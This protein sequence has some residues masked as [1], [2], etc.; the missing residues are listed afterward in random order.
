MVGV[1]IKDNHHPSAFWVKSTPAGGTSQLSSSWGRC[2][3]KH[4]DDW[5]PSRWLG[6][7][8]A[9]TQFNCQT[10]PDW[11]QTNKH[12]SWNIKKVFNAKL[13]HIYCAKKT[14]KNT[15]KKKNVHILIVVKISQVKHNTIKSG[16]TS[17]LINPELGRRPLPQQRPPV[18]KRQSGSPGE[19]PVEGNHTLPSSGGRCWCDCAA[20]PPPGC[21]AWGWAP[22]PSAVHSSWSPPGSSPSPEH[23]SQRRSPEGPVEEAAMGHV[24]LQAAVVN[25][26][27]PLS[28][29]DEAACSVLQQ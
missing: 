23:R 9:V 19:R 12:G 28:N 21:A 2:W 16:Q 5:E 13:L 8:P 10:L 3:H 24:K 20:A 4:L 29:W 22:H 17:S 14:K 15:N 26:D 27:Q 7:Q 6:T 25:A 1:K 18:L 11:K